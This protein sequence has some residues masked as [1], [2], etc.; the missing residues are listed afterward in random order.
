MFKRRY[1]EQAMK[2]FDHSGD[3]NLR[4]RALAYSLAE[5]AAKTQTESETLQYK[6]E[7][8]FKDMDKSQKKIM[9]EEISQLHQKS[10]SL[11]Y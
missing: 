2:C 10:L 9:R 3:I 1:Y 5:D 8:S 7:E 11:F 4:K 6:F